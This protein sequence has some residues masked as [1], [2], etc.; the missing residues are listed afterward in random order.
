M[1]RENFY[2]FVLNNLSLFIFVK[3]KLFCDFYISSQDRQVF[4]LNF[5]VSLRN[6]IWPMGLEKRQAK[7]F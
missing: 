7:Y 6:E 3:A 2:N 4:Y 1:N 5:E